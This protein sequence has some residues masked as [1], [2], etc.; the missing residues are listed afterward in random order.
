[1]QLSSELKNPPLLAKLIELSD[2]VFDSWRLASRSY[3]L[4]PKP[5]QCKFR[6]LRLEACLTM[7]RTIFQMVSFSCELTYPMKFIVSDLRL[8]HFSARLSRC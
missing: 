8:P 2:V 3:P 4:P 6:L 5:L 7:V 1:M